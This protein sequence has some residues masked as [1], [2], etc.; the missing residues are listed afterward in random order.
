MPST[1]YTVAERAGVSVATVSRVLNNSPKVRE[2]TKARVLKVMEELN[3]QPNASAR[4]LALNRTEVIALIFPDIS[5][6]FYTEVIRGVESEADKNNYNVLIYGTHGKIERGRFLRLLP[7]KVDG[8]ILM[9]RSVE[10]K[11]VFDLHSR[12]IAFVLLSRQIDG[13]EA[14]CIMTNNIEGAF[15]AV[16]HLLGHGHRRIGFISGPV[17]SPDS[18]ARFEGYR[19]ALQSHGLPFLPQVVERGDFLQAGGY[20]AMNRLL[21]QTD[22]PSAVF[23]ANDEMAL[24][25][26]DAVQARGLN[27]PGDIAIIGFDDIGMASFARPPLTTI[28]QPMRDLGKL[29]VRQLLRRIGTPDAQPETVRLPTQLIVRQSCC[30]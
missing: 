28:R 3:Y 30:A 1:V 19:Q 20:Q 26:I 14:D 17:D 29:A 5:G 23:A 4:G 2:K 25:A 24:G 9:A 13:L 6:P 11:Y 7:T 8:L 16:E 10:D 27:I 22:T 21:D 12:K 15:A 18:K